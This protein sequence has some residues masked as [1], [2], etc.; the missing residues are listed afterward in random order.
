MEIN[1]VRKSDIVVIVES[2]DGELCVAVVNRT[3]KLVGSGG[4][5]HQNQF[6]G[7]NAELTFS[8][9]VS[10]STLLSRF[11]QIVWGK[12]SSKELRYVF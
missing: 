12:S 10:N 7:E 9:L 11:G 1:K 5:H 8:V 3:K 4:R 2:S 6:S